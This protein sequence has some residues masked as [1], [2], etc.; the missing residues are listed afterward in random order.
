MEAAW[1]MERKETLVSLGL[2]RNGS[3]EQMVLRSSL[4]MRTQHATDRLCV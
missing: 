1:P 3:Q 4:L 2:G